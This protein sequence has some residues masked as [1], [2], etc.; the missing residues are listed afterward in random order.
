MFKKNNK[1]P[2]KGEDVKSCGF[3]L[4]PESDLSAWFELESIIYNSPTNATA[5]PCLISHQNLFQFF[6]KVRGAICVVIALLKGMSPI[7]K[8]KKDA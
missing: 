2:H 6:F 1:K 4:Q 8:K 5:A 3:D 7:K